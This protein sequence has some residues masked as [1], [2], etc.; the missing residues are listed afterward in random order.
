MGLEERLKN[1]RDATQTEPGD[2]KIR[3]TVARCKNTFHGREG[4]DAAI[5]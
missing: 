1:Y 4:K 5:P 2:E 3:E